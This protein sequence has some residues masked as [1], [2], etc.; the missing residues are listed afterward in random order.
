LAS[1]RGVSA[2]AGEALGNVAITQDAVSAAAQRMSANLAAAK[3]RIEA[4]SVRAWPSTSRSLVNDAAV[5][6]TSLPSWF[7]SDDADEI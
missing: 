7:C 4:S 5:R 2:Q 1:I 3:A 6:E